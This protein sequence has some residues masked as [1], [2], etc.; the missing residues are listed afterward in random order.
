MPDISKIQL[1]GSG[2]VYNIKDA[3][4]REMISGGVSFIVAWDGTG[5]PNISAIPAGVEVK[6]NGVSY[7]GTLDADDSDVQAGAFYLV[8][9][10]TLTSGAPSDSY[11]EYVPV[12]TAGDRSWEKI[13]DTQIDLTNVV[14]NVTLSKQ[15]DAVLGADTTFTNSSSNV[16]FGTHTTANVLG[17]GTTFSGNQSNVTF[18]GGT[19]DNVLG[20]DTSF[21]TTVTPSTTYLGATTSTDDFVTS[22]TAETNKNL[23]IT[24]VTQVGG[25][26][27]VSLVSKTD[28]A[29]KLV[30]DT[31]P[32]ITN[33]ADV[34]L[35]TITQNDAKV[36]NKSTWNFAMGSGD[37]SE[38][39]IITGGNGND[40]TATN[41]VYNTSSTASK[42]TQNGNL[43]VATGEISAVGTG[44]DVLGGLTINSK[45]VATKGS[46]VTVAAGTTSTNGT[47]AAVVTGVTV[48]STAKAVTGVSL[49]SNGSSAA[50][51]VQ[52]ATGISSASTSAT[53]SGQGSDVVSVVTNIGDGVAAGQ[54]IS[55]GSN[56]RQTV[57][58][59][60]GTATAG[61]QTITVGT[62]DEVSALT[63]STSINVTKGQ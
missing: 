1:P 22:V 25:E 56:D 20:E 40:V 61:A 12:G 34:T 10:G 17:A 45:T 51:R 52:V 43:T 33:I 29:N 38:T 6:Y 48:G 3:V 39:L 63:E 5:A 35:T 24:T 46:N 41:T 23:D 2:G 31:T 59:T 32:K 19:S 13:G 21:T 11:D 16:T 15:S 60:L 62:N 54:T 37:A 28:G 36:A 55:V 42:I 26:E 44:D 58:K 4:A 50:G 30:T 7:I 14:T 53:T 47:G 57:L 49:A 9:S 27:S 18:T 8:K